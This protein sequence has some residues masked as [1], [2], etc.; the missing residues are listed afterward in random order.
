M[1]SRSKIVNASQSDFGSCNA[2]TA[3][4]ATFDVLTQQRI[5]RLRKMAA[6][7]GP[8]AAVIL[9]QPGSLLSMQARAE[10]AAA[11]AIINVVIM[12]DEP[13]ETL[14][15]RLHRSFAVV[16]DREPDAFLSKQLI[17]HIRLRSRTHS[18]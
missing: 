14:L 2:R 1:D 5:E 12:A 6:E 7:S 4:L 8:L 13:L 9:E 15:P 16:D 17:E 10:L 11:L 3:V 18:S